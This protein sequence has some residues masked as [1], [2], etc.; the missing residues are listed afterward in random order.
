MPSAA[1][2]TDGRQEARGETGT[3]TERSDGKEAATRRGFL[4]DRGPQETQ[5]RD[6]E[7]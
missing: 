6:S 5:D 1:N 7:R 2:E 3:E 4:V